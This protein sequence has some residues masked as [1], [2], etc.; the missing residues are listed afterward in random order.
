[1]KNERL[2]DTA[3]HLNFIPHSV[4]SIYTQFALLGFDDIFAPRVECLPLGV[5]VK[6]QG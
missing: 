2:S 6:T 3:L 5:N 1:M 4:P